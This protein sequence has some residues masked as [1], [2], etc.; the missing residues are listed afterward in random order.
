MRCTPGTSCSPW[1]R[2]SARESTITEYV[3]T[4]QLAACFD[5]ALGLI[6][7]AVE[8]SGSRAAYLEGSF[9][10]GK[11]HFCDSKRLVELLGADLRAQ[12]VTAHLV[13]ASLSLDER[14]RAEQAFA[15][16]RDCVIVST[17]AL[18]LGAGTGSTDEI[19]NGYTCGDAKV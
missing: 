10:S 5:Q 3:V 14:Q 12:G 18:E 4:E 11:S 2:G 17:S 19:S 13:H 6:K 1:P 15:E 7:S 8:T 16:G 9:G